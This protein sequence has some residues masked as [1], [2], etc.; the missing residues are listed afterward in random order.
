I[1][2]EVLIYKK[3]LDFITAFCLRITN[4]YESYESAES[5]INSR[6]RFVYSYLVRNSYIRSIMRNDPNMSPIEN[7]YYAMGELAYSVASADGRVQPEERK[8]FSDID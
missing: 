5:L 4:L 7:L 8:K 6:I 2:I 1:R 3:Y